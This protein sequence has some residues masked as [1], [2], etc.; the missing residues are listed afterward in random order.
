MLGLFFSVT[1][2]VSFVVLS[3]K[4]KIK[5]NVTSDTQCR[6]ARIFSVRVVFSPKAV[7]GAFHQNIIGDV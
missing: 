4:G 5:L 2:D 7:L 3:F 6:K 1:R